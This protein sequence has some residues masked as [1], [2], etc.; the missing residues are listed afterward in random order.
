[1]ALFSGLLAFPVTP[2]DAAGR[3]DDE[4]LSRVVTALDVA[5][6]DTLGVLGS[7]GS[8]AYL[9]GALR[10]RVIDRVAALKPAHQGLVVGVGAVTTAAT[11]EL[12]QDAVA[13]GADGLL[14]AP[15]SYL[16]LNDDELVGHYHAVAAAVDRPICVYNNPATTGVDISPGLAARLMEAERIVAIKT[17]APPVGKLAITHRALCDAIGAEAVGYSVDANA[18]EALIAGGRA[19]YS[20]MAGV[21]PEP[22]AAIVDAVRGGDLELARRRDAAL[23][24]LWALCKRLSSY[25]VAHAA[26]ALKGLAEAV[27]P[28]PIRALAGKDLEDVQHTLDA[29]GLLKN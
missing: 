3:L 13:A 14:L 15:V 10:R 21:F 7:T 16:P 23:L 28:R 11:I 4:G 29:L 24:P 25:R 9:D 27:P 8:Y 12:A 20:V 2:L 5:G 26:V 6:V 18:C 17:P 19:W 1:M 22:C